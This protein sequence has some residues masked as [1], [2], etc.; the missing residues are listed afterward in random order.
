MD[1]NR[2]FVSRVNLEA[3]EQ[4]GD[5]TGQQ[6]WEDVQAV[7]ASRMPQEE[8]D[9]WIAELRLVA[10]VDGEMLLAAKA[11]VDLDRANTR[12][13]KEIERLWA[14]MDPL[15]RAIKLICWR[16]APAELRDL[17]GDPWAVDET[18]VA[19]AADKAGAGSSGQRGGRVRERP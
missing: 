7:L 9:R 10:E 16:T 12:H 14:G 8:F 11:P 6:V 1:R 13:K 15:G 18:G 2:L 17:I 3:Q 19:V 4:G 5:A